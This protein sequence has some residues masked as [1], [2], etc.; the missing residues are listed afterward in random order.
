MPKTGRGPS[1]GPDTSPHQQTCSGTKAYRATV[2]TALLQQEPASK[3]K[4][5]CARRPH[6][7]VKYMPILGKRNSERQKRHLSVAEQ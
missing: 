1:R 3:T 6:Q 2:T 4:T 7:I 5:N